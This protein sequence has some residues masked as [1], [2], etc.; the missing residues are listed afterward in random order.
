MTV[1]VDKVTLYVT[2]PVGYILMSSMVLNGVKCYNIVHNSC[3]L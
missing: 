3:N 1:K 2:M